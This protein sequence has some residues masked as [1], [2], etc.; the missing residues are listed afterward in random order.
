MKLPPTTLQRTPP[1][2]IDHSGT[3]AEVENSD[4]FNTVYLSRPTGHIA[5]SLVGEG[6]LI[7]CIPGM[8]DVRSVYRSLASALAG[9]GFRVAAIDLRSHGDSDVTFD[10]YDDVAA[11]SDIIALAE[12]LGGPA[13]LIG[14]S[15][16]TGAACWA[17]AE[18]PVLTTGLVLLGPFVRDAKTNVAGKLL[19]RLALLRP[20]GPAAW[21]AY[22]KKL[23]PTRS[24]AAY[25]ATSSKPWGAD[26]EDRLVVGFAHVLRFH[27]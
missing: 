27:W 8:G 4:V 15:M 6:Q 7:I 12:R 11:C 13:I 19:L 21:R 22:F 16:G 10:T 17:A 2:S 14:N 24:D 3:K 1:F 23:Y 18:A 25:D 20:W 9:A 26:Q 5:F